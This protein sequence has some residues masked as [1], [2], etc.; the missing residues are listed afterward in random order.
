MN[1]ILK[2]LALDLFCNLRNGWKLLRFR[3]VE[4]DEFR[5]GL[6]QAVTLVL[7]YAFI[8][9]ACSLISNFSNPAFDINGMA[10][11]ATQT[12]FILLFTYIISRTTKIKI[13]TIFVIVLSI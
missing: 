1:K 3:S 11:I 5:V 9:F 13:E 8:T 6:N 2:N 10:N 12:S 4:L 7:F